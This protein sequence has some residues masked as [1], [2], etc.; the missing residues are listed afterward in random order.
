MKLRIVKD[1]WILNS[2]EVVFQVTQ[3]DETDKGIE[4]A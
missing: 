4:T 1:F 2:Y 3:Q